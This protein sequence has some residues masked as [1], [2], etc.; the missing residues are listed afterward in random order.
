MAQITHNNKQKK[1]HC[2]WLALEESNVENGRVEVEKLE[3][4][5]LKDEAV[6][7]FWNSSR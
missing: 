6:F 2:H 5:H 3:Y 1:Q 4:K 7:K